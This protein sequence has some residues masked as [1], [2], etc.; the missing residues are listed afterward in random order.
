MSTQREI[1]GE[2]KNRIA[3][4][5]GALGFADCVYIVDRESEPIVVD[6]TCVRVLL[7]QERTEHPLSAAWLA[8]GEIAVGIVHPNHADRAP[9]ADERIAGADGILVIA[10]AVRLSLNQSFLEHGD[11]DEPLL[12]LP[13][14]ARS[15]G[16]PEHL[17]EDGWVRI[18]DIYS[19]GREYD[20][21]E[22][23]A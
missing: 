15:F 7:R 22:D 8:T 19:Y 11:D 9:R 3:A 23:G 16:S 20:S 5:M 18:V 13:M 21:A 12:I 1:L 17:D 10:D 2:I 4:A 6:S 14:L